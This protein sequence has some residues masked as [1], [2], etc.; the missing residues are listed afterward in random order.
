MDRKRPTQQ[1]EGLGQ[2]IGQPIS[3]HYQHAMPRIL[4][5]PILS[6]AACMES[7]R[8]PRTVSPC[9]STARSHPLSLHRPRLRYVPRPATVSA[10][11]HACIDIDAS[12]RRRFSVIALFSKSWN[13]A[14]P[15][16]YFSEPPLLHGLFD[17]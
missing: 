1:R 11:I 5:D 15:S 2:E 7:P 16:A 6:S 12:G 3:P 10:S 17:H 9:D 13:Q 4:H 14:A 8:L